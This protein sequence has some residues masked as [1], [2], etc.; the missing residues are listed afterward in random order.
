MRAI[1]ITT[2]HESS[3]LIL[4]AALKLPERAQHTK[5]RFSPASPSCVTRSR[6]SRW[7]LCSQKLS[8]K[9]GAGQ[10][11][12]RGAWQRDAA[13]A[14]APQTS[15]PWGLLHTGRSQETRV[16]PLSIL[17]GLRAEGLCWKMAPRNQGG[18][19]RE[20]LRSFL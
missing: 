5:S 20:H 4:A 9:A 13:Q 12:P 6:T 2:D 7:C 18:E 15:V 14:V 11:L 16:R 3:P 8:R 10:G 1:F 17:L 19:Q